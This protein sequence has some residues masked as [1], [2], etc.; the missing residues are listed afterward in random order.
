MFKLRNIFTI[1]F[2]ILTMFAFSNSLLLK[3]EKAYEN[4]EYKKAIEVYEQ[5][6]KDGYVSY[7]LYY[8]LGN[9]YYRNNQL[10][11]AIYNYE[12]AKKINYKDEDIKN[13]LAL[14]YTKT[15]DKIEVKEN[16]FI[17]AVKTNVLSSF[18]TKAWA[19]L[20]IG[21]SALFFLFLYLFIAGSSV[22]LKRISFFASLVFII[23]F[24]IVY[25]LGN[26][27]KKANEENSFAIITAPET[28]V[29]TEPT[30]ASSSKFGLHEG[31]RVRIVEINADW[32]LIKLENGNEGW[33]KLNDVG[34]F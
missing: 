14:A 2:V 5:L 24:F 3:A 23:A 7:Q 6:V 19:W 8:N 15:I 33:L 28:K 25:F 1:F 4:R 10:G 21:A 27:A 20:S 9:A 34:V 32:I 30:A 22:A 29:Y 18:S 12:R 31:T 16:F 13:N 17:S 11:K 26:S